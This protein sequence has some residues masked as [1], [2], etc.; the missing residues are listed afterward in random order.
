MDIAVEL[1]KDKA[2]KGF[3]QL[4]DEADK[5]FDKTGAS[6]QK[7]GGIM[8]R[9]FD[10][11]L[12][13]AEKFGAYLPQL[14]LKIAKLAAGASL[15][16][17]A[18]AAKIGQLSI[19]KFS[20]FE[21]A[22]ANVSTLVDTATVD[23]A[24]LKKGIMALPPELGSA[25]ANAEALYQ[26]LSAGM[27]PAKSVAFVAQAAKAA[28]AGLSD[29]FTAV[30]AGTTVL[31]AFGL[32]GEEAGAIFDQMFKTVEQG[33]TTFTE[34][35]GSI[36][37]LS[38][39]AAAASVS[40]GEMFAAIA[41]LTKGGFATTEAV[42]RMATALGAVIKPSAEAS[43]LAG[44]LGLQFDAAALKSQGLAG[45]L[46]S[47]KTATN[48]DVE[49]MGQLFGGM[50][51]LS[52]MLAL[53]GEQS[54]EF[55]KILGEI[56]NSAGSVDTAF[57]KQKNTLDSLWETFKNT[58]GKQA[59]FL[60][61]QLA[62]VVKETIKDAGAWL[63]KN[64]ELVQSEIVDFAKELAGGIKAI[65][66]NVQ[67]LLP[68]MSGLWTVTKG[69]ASG[70]NSIGTAIGNTVGRIDNLISKLNSI[71]GLGSVMGTAVDI[72]WDQFGWGAVQGAYA[73]GTDYVPKTGLYQL[74]QGE[75]VIPAV[76][77][78]PQP[79][80]RGVTIQ[81]DI[82]IM[83][84]ANAAPRQPEDWRYIVRSIIIPELEAAGA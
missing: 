6:S 19:G 20:G 67:N 65:S 76:E 28:K 27:D 70:I 17:G 40:T 68:F 73:K 69:V 74:H 21:S 35:A 57:D 82:N 18:A 71:P 39:I 41:T 61:E 34:L 58:I 14:G 51:S 32:E 16:L 29:T 37:K 77:N 80:G 5:A 15:A 46:D 42:S 30:D 8:S 31:N 4:G 1:E 48:G 50:E 2:V 81:G 44:E 55:V 45:F 75:A 60:G 49:A 13:G 56:E 53:T 43:K 47:I 9:S 25:T 23:M 11:M 72:A 54:G 84:P 79:G 3:R 10:K 38:P 22:M 24:A 36:G 52:V 7:A 62:P 26:A 83:V 59:I 66:A 63:E 12:G 78:R 64:Q 33:K